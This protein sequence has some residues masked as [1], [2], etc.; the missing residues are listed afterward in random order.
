MNPSF[1]REDTRAV[2]GLAVLLVLMH[3]IWFFPERRPLFVTA[4][5][6]PANPWMLNGQDIFTALSGFAPISMGFFLFLTGYGLYMQY[7]SGKLSLW[8]RIK[9]FYLSFWKVFLIVIP[10]S[11]LFFSNQE[12]IA[13]PELNF[14]SRYTAF[15]AGNTI[16]NLFGLSDSYNGEW[17][18]V[19][20]YVISLVVG[21]LFILAAG[22][23]SN[24][25]IEFFLVACINFV[26]YRILPVLFAQ[27]W[28][29]QITAGPFYHF[30][31][32]HPGMTCVFS[33]IVFAK[34]ALADRVVCL[35]SQ[36]IGLIRVLI[37][38]GTI[39]A[40]FYLRA[41]TGDMFDFITV[42]FF[43]LSFVTLLQTP[44]HVLHSFFRFIG[45][46]S[47][48]IWLTHSFFCY[49]WIAVVKV[50]FASK[51]ALLSF[52]VLLLFSLVT[53]VVIDL[54]YYLIRKAVHM[55]PVRAKS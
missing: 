3:H 5:S 55:I 23:L 40:I 16:M 24:C 2:K 20:A 39:T 11:F 48:N 47:E 35:L 46:Y 49:Y 33:G 50:V 9:R 14:H 41:Y 28:A 26:F 1:S 6:S 21:Y 43:I 34:Y 54:I 10:I 45:R 18:F 42:P 37:C 53:A 7:R 12:L 38:A 27:P 25:Y 22:K 15:S 19:L 36:R 32:I 4:W 13:L 44:F 31:F 29:A 30:Y 8:S 51:N 17:W 52:L